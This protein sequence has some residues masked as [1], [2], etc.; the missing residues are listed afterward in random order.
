MSPKEQSDQEDGGKQHDVSL[1][2]P[3]SG[4]TY[5]PQV[6]AALRINTNSSHGEIAKL[7]H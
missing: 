4:N 5:L 7:V 2:S 3:K 1:F 6:K